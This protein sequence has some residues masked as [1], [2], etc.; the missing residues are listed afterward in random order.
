[1]MSLS[2][3]NEPEI[4]YKIVKSL[5]KC[6]E[7]IDMIVYGIQISINGQSSE[8]RDISSDKNKVE[9]LLHKLKMNEVK[10]EQ[11]GTIKEILVENASPVEYGQPLF[12]IE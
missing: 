3:E 8:I 6:E 2:Q 11:C 4:V 1:M 9:N 7:N 12:I 5:T 10:A